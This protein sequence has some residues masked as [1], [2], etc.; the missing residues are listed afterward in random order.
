M[1]SYHH[2]HITHHMNLY[3]P[4]FW[5]EIGST[6]L[7]C[8]ILWSG[9]KSASDDKLWTAKDSHKRSHSRATKETI[10]PNFGASYHL[11]KMRQ[12]LLQTTTATTTTEQTQFAREEKTTSATPFVSSYKPRLSNYLCGIEPS[13][14]I[15]IWYTQTHASIKMYFIQNTVWFWGWTLNK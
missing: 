11:I 10:M 5:V 6:P 12:E 4:C 9:D 2:W 14:G 8:N 3:T 1:W 7:C 15:S 13:L